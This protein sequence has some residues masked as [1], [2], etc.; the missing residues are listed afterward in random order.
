MNVAL[1]MAA[2]SGTRMNSETPKQ[3]IEVNGKPILWWTLKTFND[4]KN[5]DAIFV[6]T[7]KSYFNKVDEISVDFEK[8]IGNIE[9]GATR[10]ES[11]FNGLKY[12]SKNGFINDDI[13]LIHDGARPLVN[14]D[15]IKNN[16]EGCREFDAVDTVVP[17]NDSIIR[18]I[19]ASTI[20]QSENRKELFQNQ[21]PQ[22][23]KLGLILEA[24]NKL[25]NELD[26]YTDDCQIAIKNGC[27]IHLVEGSKL[28]FKVTTKEDLELLEALLSKK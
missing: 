10:Q 25:H 12:I 26:K 27:E 9:G 23:F 22:T 15:I 21:T 4:S 28:N 11:V 14:E 13:V 7:N 5:I 18:S 2:G 8:V 17:A 24:Y 1:I 3:F 20:T 19:D 16:V 6:V